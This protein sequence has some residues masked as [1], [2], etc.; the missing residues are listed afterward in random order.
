[1]RFTAAVNAEYENFLKK[2]SIRVSG[3]FFV[4]DGVC[5]KRLVQEIEAIALRK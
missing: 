3:A 4:S 2:M 5:Q 1:M